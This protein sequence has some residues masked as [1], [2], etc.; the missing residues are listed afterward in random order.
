[1]VGGVCGGLGEWLGLDPLLVRVAAIVTAAA[2]GAGLVAYAVAWVLLPAAAPGSVV[3]R[4]DPAVPQRVL[5][6]V[7]VTLAVI[8]VVRRAGIPYFDLVVWPVALF[9]V[10]AAVLWRQSDPERVAVTGGRNTTART[11]FRLLVGGALTVAAGLW[12]VLSRR[13]IAL[14]TTAPIVAVVAVA[15]G[16]AVVFA[17]WLAR[18]VRAL[19]SERA[20]RIREQER[21]EVAAHL[22]D[23]V[24]QSLALIQRQAADPAAVAG[25]AR[26]QERQLRDWLYGARDDVGAADLAASI[27]SV[28]SVVEADYRISIEVVCVGD[29]A[30][31]PR[32]RALVAATREALTNAAKWSGVGE[33]SVYAEVDPAATVAT[34]FVRDRGLGFDPDAVPDGRHGIAESIRGRMARHGGSAEVAT[35]QGA[36]TEVVLRMPLGDAR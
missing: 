8:L 33:V 30:L 15:V 16:L 18:L 31:G 22:H 14:S 23:S 35:E 25:I 9:S 1:M 26:A 20:E 17:P 10:G 7:L 13:D 5:G 11:V 28:A 29:V 24:L 19:Q 2:A 36:G 21:A 4:Q 3:A 34:V 27:R 12:L 32:T 6:L